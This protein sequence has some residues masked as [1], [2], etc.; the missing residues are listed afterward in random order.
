MKS[1]IPQPYIYIY[2]VSRVYGLLGLWF[3]AKK[4]RRNSKQLNLEWHGW[5]GWFGCHCSTVQL[6]QVM[7]MLR[8][9]MFFFIHVFLHGLDANNPFF[10]SKNAMMTILGGYL[11][12]GLCIVWKCFSLAN[13][14]LPTIWN[15]R[16]SQVSGIRGF[17]AEIDAT[18]T[19]LNLHHICR[20]IS[21]KSLQEVL[22]SSG[23]QQFLGLHFFDPFALW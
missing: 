4:R 10:G 20:R 3:F 7:A 18:V 19:I 16:Y 13:K 14:W 8:P 11:Q 6:R 1:T 9:S 17:L 12:Q 23:L 5:I 21:T 2:E 22:I 15:R